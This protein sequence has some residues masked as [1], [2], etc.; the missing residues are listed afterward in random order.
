MKPEIWFQQF[1]RVA[2][3]DREVLAHG[4]GNPSVVAVENFAHQFLMSTRQIVR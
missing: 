1:E 3:P 4:S 2:P